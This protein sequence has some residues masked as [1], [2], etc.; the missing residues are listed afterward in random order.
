VEVISGEVKGLKFSEGSGRQR[1]E[2]IQ[3][4]ILLSLEISNKVADLVARAIH[5]SNTFD[6]GEEIKFCSSIRA[7]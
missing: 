2:R 3:T 7:T 6:R 1:D 5:P 4:C